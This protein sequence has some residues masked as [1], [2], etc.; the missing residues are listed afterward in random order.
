MLKEKINKKNT[1]SV[2]EGQSAVEVEINQSG[3][4]T[5]SATGTIKSVD[6]NGCTMFGY[7]LSELIDKPITTII[8]SPYKEQ[9][10][11]YLQ[12]YANTGVK[13]IIGTSRIAEAQHKDGTIFPVRLSVSEV[14]C[15]SKIYVGLI[16]KIEPFNA[17][18][19]CTSAGAL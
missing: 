17:E 6:K 5:I 19:I 15:P 3:L 1:M 14:N 10:D 11:L 12:R 2:G 7:S 8:P 16:E 4:F 13:K 18:L 9:H